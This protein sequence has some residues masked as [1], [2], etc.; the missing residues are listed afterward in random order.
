MK[1]LKE[2]GLKFTD[3]MIGVV[4]GL[5]FNYW[6]D[7]KE[8]WQYLAFVF[9]YFNLID[10]WIDYSPTL[11][12]FPLKGEIDVV[13]HTFIVFAMFFLV[14]ATKMTVTIFFLSFIFYRLVDILWIW[15]MKKEYKM[16]GKDKIFM[17]AWNTCDGIEIILSV[18]LIGLNLFNV[19]NALLIIIIFIILRTISRIWASVK[20]K[21]LYYIG[22]EG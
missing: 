17:G 11:K 22:S 3:I 12:R 16:D 21:N 6:P 14:Y 15:R 19:L 13:L 9:V 5:G 1:V 8:I 20:Y 10:Y 18:L 2:F 4:L 7:L